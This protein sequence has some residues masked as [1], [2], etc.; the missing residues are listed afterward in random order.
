MTT[1]YFNYEKGL[2]LHRATECPSVFPLNCPD[3]SFQHKAFQNESSPAL[4]PPTNSYIL[5][6][7]PVATS[8]PSHIRVST[9]C[10]S[11]VGHKDELMQQE[12]W[13]YHFTSISPQHLTD[14]NTSDTH[15]CLAC[16]AKRLHS[17][18]RFLFP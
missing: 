12:Q 7:L 16:Q 14:L 3:S 11:W 10:A 17:V 5:L 15:Y 18:S 6:S 8:F 1:I 4:N 9:A 13:V 2:V